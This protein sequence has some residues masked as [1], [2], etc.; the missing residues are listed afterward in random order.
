MITIATL[1]WEPNAQSE[2]F[3]TMYTEEW[4]ERLYRGCQRNLTR[5]FNFVLF[6]DQARIYREPIS[7]EL[8]SNPHPGYGDCIE[9]Y[10]LNEPMILMGLDTVITGNIDH[11][12]DYCLN[13]SR[14]ALP[15]DPFKPMQAC[16]GVSLVPPGQADV[17]N[18]WTGQNDMEWARAQPHDFIDDL[19][20]GQ[21]RSYKC[22]VKHGGLGD[23]RIVYFHGKEKPHELAGAEPWIS[24]HWT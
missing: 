4:V 21:V 5:P 12:A 23:A 20:P 3:S 18:R 16:N 9:P 10:R 7:Q 11:L 17:W 14:I 19:F 2:P 24:E 1:F 6:T 22:H 13:A 8:M 15:R